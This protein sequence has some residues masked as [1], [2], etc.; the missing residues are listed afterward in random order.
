M[1]AAISPVT[2]R[3]YGK[4][5]IL[6]SVADMGHSADLHLWVDATAGIAGDMLL[7]ALIDAGAPLDAVEPAVSAV[8]PGEV[9]LRTSTVHR[10]GLR[11]LK[12][13]VESRAHEHHHRSWS[14]IR[15]MLETAELP[16]AVRTTALAAFA[17]R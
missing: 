15:S 2:T 6:H 1:P 14:H 11:A 3:D 16:S 5:A 4:G 8:V 17:S 9:A 13:D 12:L 10:A 7:G